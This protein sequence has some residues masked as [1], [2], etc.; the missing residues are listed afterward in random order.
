MVLGIFKMIATS[1]FLTKCTKFV[2]SRG[3]APYPNG[4]AYSDRPDPVAGLKG[5]ILLRRWSRGQRGRR[6]R[7]YGTGGTA[8]LSQIPKSAPDI[9]H[10]LCL[11]F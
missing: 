4:G 2:F 11:R 7:E 8:P 3:S 6:M 10:L 5:L 9:M 1:G